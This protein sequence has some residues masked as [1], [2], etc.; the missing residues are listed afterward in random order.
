MSS[1]Q[2]AGLS[3]ALAVGLVLSVLLLGSWPPINVDSDGGGPLP[4][5]GVAPTSTPAPGTPPPTATV[6]PAPTALPTPTTPAS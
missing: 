5:D 1:S 4:A 3:A 2:W 6:T